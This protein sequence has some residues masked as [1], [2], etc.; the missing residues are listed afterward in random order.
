MSGRLQMRV[1]PVPVRWTPLDVA[2]LALWLKADAIAGLANGATIATLPDVSGNGNDAT[3]SIAAKKPTFQLNQINTHPV[4]RSDGDDDFLSLTGLSVGGGNKTFFT[5]IKPDTTD[6]GETL[7]D[8]LTGRLVI[9]PSH[10]T[11]GQVGYFDGGWKLTGVVI[12]A[13]WQYLV[14][15]LVLGGTNSIVYKNGAALG[16]AMTYSSSSIGDGCALLSDYAGLTRFFN[17]DLLEFG[18]FDGSLSSPDLALL[19]AYL[20]ARS[21]I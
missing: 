2:G 18:I 17:G 21:G 5:I 12:V 6:F 10:V 1:P 16:S 9:A 15:D 13:E 7:F 14:W 19:H 3:Q 4:V 8:T 11:A 20:S